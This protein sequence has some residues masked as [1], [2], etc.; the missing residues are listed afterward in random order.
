MYTR[1]MGSEENSSGLECEL[2]TALIIKPYSQK[3]GGDRSP[4]RR[5]G[6]GSN[7]IKGSLEGIIP[8]AEERSPEEKTERTEKKK[9][10]KGF[11]IRGLGF[12][13]LV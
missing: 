4:T 5:V 7:E 9:T 8:H 10:K 3:C 12:R 6:H 2:T 13:I 11:V 1:T